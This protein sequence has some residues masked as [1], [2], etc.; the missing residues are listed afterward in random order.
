MKDLA[1]LLVIVV[2]LVFGA[3]Q[4][5]QKDVVVKEYHTR[6]TI[7][8]RD[9]IS[10]VQKGRIQYKTI[11]VKDT[12]LKVDS[13]AFVSCV[14][15]IISKSSVSV[16]YQYPENMFSVDLRF[17]PDTV[18]KYTIVER[19]I[20]KYEEKRNSWWEDV[21]KIGGGIIVGYLLGLVK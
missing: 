18:T 20:L 3:Y 16:C 14:D 15:T 13:S 17:I 8:V 10:I 9:T 11:L 2:L 6:D 12:I 1:Y 5:L 19:P 4:Y 21:A 7:L